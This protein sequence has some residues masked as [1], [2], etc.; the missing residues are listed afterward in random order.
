MQ[1][2]GSEAVLKLVGNA[3]GDVGSVPDAIR[4]TIASAT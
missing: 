3:C 4:A 2:I 1:T